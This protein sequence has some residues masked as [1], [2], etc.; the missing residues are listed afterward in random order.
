MNDKDD[1]VE[2]AKHILVSIGLPASLQN[3]RSAW[4]LLALLQLKSGMGWSEATNPLLRINSII[5]WIKTE[6]GQDYKENTRES[7]RKETV[8]HLVDA[9]VLLKNPDHPNRAIN[10][11]NTFYQIE[12]HA[13]TLIQ[14]YGSDSWDESLAGYRS[15]HEALVTRYARE[16][17]LNAVPVRLRPGLLSDLSPGKHSEL[18]RSIVEVFAPY[19]ASGSEVVYIGDTSHKWLHTEPILVAELGIQVDLHGKMPDVL[20]YHRERNWLFVIEAVT[21]RGPIDGKRHQE[22]TDLFSHVSARLVYVTAFQNR[23]AFRKHVGTIAWETEVWL[24]DSPTHLIH[25]D[26]DKFLGPYEMA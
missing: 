3:D 17:N 11:P 4:C 5:K 23:A 16:R 14:Q 2:A 6:Y 20:L 26:G 7:I 12:P 13:L 9:G 21:S 15:K 25:F 18:I 10:S 8:H 22:L 24:A 1:Q 19:F